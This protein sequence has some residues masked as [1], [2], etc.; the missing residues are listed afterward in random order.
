MIVGAILGGVVAPV[1]QELINKVFKKADKTIGIHSAVLILFLA[2]ATWI[3]G[4]AVIQLL[5]IP[6]LNKTGHSYGLGLIIGITL[7]ILASLALWVSYQELP[8]S[9]QGEQPVNLSLLEKR[10]GPLA[11]FILGNIFWI[12]GELIQVLFEALSALFDTNLVLLGLLSRAVTCAVTVVLFSLAVRQI[13]QRIPS[14]K[15]QPLEA[16]K[17]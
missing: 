13:W 14:A 17:L 3:I 4:E 2:N 11:L 15:E 1:G 9:Q 8:Q 6:N 7:F 16:P 5:Y 12:V 10:D